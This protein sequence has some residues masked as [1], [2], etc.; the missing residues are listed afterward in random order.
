[1]AQVALLTPEGNDCDTPAA[2][3]GSGGTSSTN[4][5]NAA[6]LATMLRSHGLEVEF[7]KYFFGCATGVSGRK[8]GPGS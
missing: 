8:P 1:L 7:S 6:E 4:F 5:G 3:R 2:S